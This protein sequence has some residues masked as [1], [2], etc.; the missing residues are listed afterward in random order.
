[1]K[2]DCNTLSRIKKNL[3]M[4][5][6]QGISDAV[7]RG[8]IN[9]DEMGKRVVLPA[10]HVG[11]R[12]YMFQNYHDGLAICRVYGPPDFLVTFTCNPNWPE[13]TE[14]LFEAGQTPPDRS[15]V[16]VRVYHLKLNELLQDI[17]SGFIF[18]PFV[19]GTF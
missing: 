10:S 19:A 11:G 6:I 2:V 9:G 3:R 8:C 17:K 4:E 13:I 5:S 14:R 7:G 18:G 12:H 16:I 1:M 15:D